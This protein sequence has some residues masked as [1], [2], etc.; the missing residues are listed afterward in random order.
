MGFKKLAES[1]GIEAP[2]L[3]RLN[4]GV[5]HLKGLGLLAELSK[6]ARVL[7]D[8]PAKLEYEFDEYCHWTFADDDQSKSEP[9]YMM[10]RR[11]KAHEA[12][13]PI[14]CSPAIVSSKE[15]LLE[16]RPAAK[17]AGPRAAFICALEERKAAEEA[18]QKEWQD[19]AWHK[20]V[21]NVSFKKEAEAIIATKELSVDIKVRPPPT[22]PQPHLAPTLATSQP[23]LPPL[24]IAGILA[25]LSL[26][27]D[28]SCGTST[29]IVSRG[30]S[31]RRC[32]ARTRGSRSSRSSSRR[33]T[34]TGRTPTGR[35]LST[36]SCRYA[37]SPDLPSFHGLP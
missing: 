34:P 6:G 36:A 27:L 3:L 37:I 30:C 13:S 1:L 23:P 10:A 15:I 16:E 8:D 26:P 22:L 5:P 9:S 33:Q 25:A 2:E 35:T 11:L 4:R 20:V 12:R 32:C 31:S 7:I 14:D 19:S 24:T 29:R 21:E 28:R 17:P 18:A